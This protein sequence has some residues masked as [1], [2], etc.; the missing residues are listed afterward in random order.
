MD[1][2]SE[3]PISGV[4][5]A[6]GNNR[7]M[8]GRM[9]AMLSLKGELF[10][11]RQLT[12]MSIICSEVLIITNEP[13]M[14]EQQLSWPG[15]HVRL[16]CDQQPGKG[17]LAGLQA[18]MAV[19]QYNELWVVACDM[20]FIS[21]RA[22]EMLLTLRRSQG[23]AGYDAAVPLL[24]GRLQPLHAIYHRRCHNVVNELLEAEQYRMMGLLER[25][26]Y[27][28][29]ESSSFMDKGISLNFAENVNT[30]EELRSLERS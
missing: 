29:A 9:K 16:V 23:E 7:R 11:E 10:I 26:D 18:A 22:A 14:F 3:P 6:G 27:A 8:G 13:A 30:P 25:L 28:E 17:P 15:Q 2:R 12:E 1:Y 5:L 4:I 19:A 24:N 20:P 21:S